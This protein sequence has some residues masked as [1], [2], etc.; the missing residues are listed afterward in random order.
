MALASEPIERGAEK[1]APELTVAPALV[2]RVAWPGRVLTG[3][4]RF[5]QRALCDQVLAAGGSK[6]AADLVADFLGRP[7]NADAFNRWLAAAPGL[8]G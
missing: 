3:D 2:A 8:A 6:D 4:A 5:C 1:A 7:Y